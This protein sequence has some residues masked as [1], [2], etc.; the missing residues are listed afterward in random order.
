LPT[1]ITIR[2]AALSKFVYHDSFPPQTLFY[3]DRM[4]SGDSGR[5]NTEDDAKDGDGGAV[6]EDTDE[7]AG[8]KY[9]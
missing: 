9:A 4:C 2:A 6:E 1:N 3:D 7:A 8:E 5:C